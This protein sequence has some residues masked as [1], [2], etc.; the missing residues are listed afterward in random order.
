MYTKID[1]RGTYNLV[2]INEGDEWKTSF[3]THYGHFKYVV[4]PLNFINAPIVFPHSMSAFFCQYL[5]DFI[6]CYIDDIFIFSKNMKECEWY[7]WYVLDKF[8]KV[9]FH[10]KLKKCKFL[11]YMSRYDIFASKSCKVQIIMD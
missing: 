8:K 3:Q 4:M 9:G 11:M 2:Y 6:G 10:A 5:D 7:V 1:L